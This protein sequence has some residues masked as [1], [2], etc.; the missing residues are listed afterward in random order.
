M[1]KALNS[2]FI[3]QLIDTDFL[4]S[5]TLSNKE[6]VNSI[7]LT[8]N[9]DNKNIF[10]MLDIF[11]I[12]SSLKQFIRILQLLKVN[13][14]FCINIWCT[15]KFILGLIDK[16]VVDFSLTNYVVASST[17]PK[18]NPK[19]KLIT[20]KNKKGRSSDRKIHF[21][22]ILGNPWTQKFDTLINTRILQS[23]IF[24]INKL[25]FNS[26]KQNFGVY[27]IQNDLSDYKK[28]IVLLVIIYN[29]LNNK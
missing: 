2:T 29:I 28:L 21:L 24:L 14:N 9:L 10:H 16:F 23:N 18:I 1:S 4:F 6:N 11:R 26:E 22:F 13:K 20:N 27:K 3:K 25:N 5:K 12:N 7:N 15:N 8:L 19:D 17:F